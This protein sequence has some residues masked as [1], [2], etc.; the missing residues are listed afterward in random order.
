MVR[1]IPFER[2]LSE[3]IPGGKDCMLIG[4]KFPP[5]RIN[6]AGDI[7]PVI[8]EFSNDLCLPLRG[9]ELLRDRTAAEF[10]G[11]VALIRELSE[12]IFPLVGPHFRHNIDFAENLMRGVERGMID[13][14]NRERDSTIERDPRVARERLLAV[15]SRIGRISGETLSRAVTV[16][17]EL[18]GSCEHGSTLGRE[19]EFVHSHTIHHHAL[20]A[21]KLRANAV[22]LPREFGVAP[23]TLKFWESAGG[24]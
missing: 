3:F 10:V 11:A 5:E 9:I 7:L 22:V 23:S 13:Y 15:A 14:A 21:E 2:N 8:T 18:D 16:K 6:R 17:S 1:N 4:N 19:L 20:I 12:E 24:N